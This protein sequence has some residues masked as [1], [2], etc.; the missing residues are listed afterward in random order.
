MIWGRKKDLETHKCLVFLIFI[1]KSEEQKRISDIFC[2]RLKPKAN[3][4]DILHKA[5]WFLN[6]FTI[7]SLKRGHL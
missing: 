4:Y 2:I 3:F 7:L 6:V 1:E 5:W